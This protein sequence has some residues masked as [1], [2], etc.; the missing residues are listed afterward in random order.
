MAVTEAPGREEIS[1]MNEAAFL[2]CNYIFV[3]LQVFLHLHFFSRCF[4]D[5]LTFLF[6]VW[7]F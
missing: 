3:L 4:K 2:I 1:V 5:V 6:L 7:T